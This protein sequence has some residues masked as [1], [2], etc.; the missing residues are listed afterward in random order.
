[1]AG[2]KVRVYCAGPLFNAKEREGMEELATYLEAA[3]YDTF[4]PQRDGF[5]LTRIVDALV[6]KNID[7]RQATDV[8]AKAIFALDVYQVIVE[9]QAIVVNLN[10][11]VPDEGAVSEAAIAWCNGK[12]VVGYKA[13]SR[14]AFIGH[15]N[16][17]VTGLFNFEVC[18]SFDA[19]LERLEQELENHQDDLGTNRARNREIAAYLTLGS[20]IW[21]AAHQKGSL[22]DI[23]DVL[24][25]EAT[26]SCAQVQMDGP[27]RVAADA[28]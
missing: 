11:R 2:Q 27:K 26:A 16:P 13:D 6:A 1:M 19:V 17:L 22:E 8:C 10:G 28:V 24:L 5:E 15:D 18:A 20:R 9:C 23:A 7:L 25:T 21:K 3:G 14:S 12:A 4:L